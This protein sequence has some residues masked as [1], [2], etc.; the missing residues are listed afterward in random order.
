MDQKEWRHLR[1]TNKNFLDFT[2]YNKCRKLQK[3]LTHNPD[4]NAKVIH[5][6]RDT[7]EQR[8]Y[9]DEHY[10]MWGFNEDGTFE[11]GKYVI[12]VTKE[13]HT[14]IHSHSDET[15]QKMSDSRKGENCYWYGKH[16]DAA[17]KEKLSIACKGKTSGKNN[18][19]YGK[20]H[21]E[22]TKE[23]LSKTNLGK[24][25]SDETKKKISESNK[26]NYTDERKQA[27]SIANKN[28][29]L[30]DETKE[31][32]SNANKGKVRSDETKKKLSKALKDRYANMTDEEKEAISAARKKWYASLSDEDKEKLLG[33]RKGK[34]L[35]DEH[36]QHI[37]A[38]LK[39]RVL[40]NETRAKISA[41]NK[42]K[43]QPPLS[44]SAREI[45][46]KKSKEH[47]A[48]VKELY[49][50]HKQSGGT[51]K[52]NEFQKQVKLLYPEQFK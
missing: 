5:H 46:S 32:I 36:K 25:H 4:P 45:I 40:S 41:S 22:E 3:E 1:D 43:Q 9:N 14:N 50:L 10:E 52:W 12:F 42:G 37:S 30:S 44:K 38:G 20:H 34:S 15:K 28:K 39:G 21:T 2:Y 26:L 47:L 19:M 27:I 7:E 6:L 23:F 8:K 17:T 51:L 16:R 29:V 13:E 49:L 31:K 33:N 18:G 35:S 24:K 48:I 11:Y